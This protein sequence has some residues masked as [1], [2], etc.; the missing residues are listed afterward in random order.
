MRPANQQQAEKHMEHLLNR[1][2]TGNRHTKVKEH[3]QRAKRIAAIIWARFQVGPYQYQLKHL[4]WYLQTQTTHLKPATRYRYWLTIQNIL[5][6]LNKQGEWLC[7][8]QG[9]WK[10]LATAKVQGDDGV[11]S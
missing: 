11:E 4:H 8:L 2:L 3:T 9:A 10:T 5:H 1:K 6:A 7:W